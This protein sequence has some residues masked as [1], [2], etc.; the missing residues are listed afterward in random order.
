MADV[1]RAARDDERVPINDDGHDLQLHRRGPGGSVPRREHVCMEARVA[2]GLA[3]SS[4]SFEFLQIPWR[5][6]MLAIAA[7]VCYSA[8]AAF[9]TGSEA[10]KAYCASWACFGV[11]VCLCMRPERDHT[12]LV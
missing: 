6:M 10:S 7:L 1:R 5:G 9:V 2:V 4:D 12:C 8:T 11:S 3:G